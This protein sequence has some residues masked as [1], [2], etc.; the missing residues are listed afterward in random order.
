MNGRCQPER[1]EPLYPATQVSISIWPQQQVEMFRRQT[2]TRQ[3]HWH[4][5]GSLPQQ[6]HERGEVIIDMEDVTSAT[7]PVQDMVNKS[8]S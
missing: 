1:Y 5:F 7:A 6:T 8:D 3:T 4:H 2:N